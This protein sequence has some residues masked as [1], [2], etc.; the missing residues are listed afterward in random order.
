MLHY[1]VHLPVGLAA[2]REVVVLEGI[3]EAGQ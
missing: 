3:H 1:A 2:C